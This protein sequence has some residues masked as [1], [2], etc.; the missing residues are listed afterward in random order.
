VGERLSAALF[1]GGLTVAIVATVLSLGMSFPVA[2]MLA[3]L[4][5]VRLVAAMVGLNT[6][7]L[8]AA[9]WGVAKAAPISEDYVGGVALAAIGAA[10]AAGLKA[11]ELSRRAD[12]PLA[13]WLVIVL[14]LANLVAVPLWA[15]A[16]VAGASLGP[17]RILPSLLLLVLLPLLVGVLVRIRWAAPATTLRTWLFR[18]GNVALVVALAA[19]IVT[20]RDL[21]LSVLGSWVLPT[22]LAI[23]ALGLGLGLLV[24]GSD[25]PTRV[26]TSLISGTRFS[27]LGLIIVGTQYPDRSEYLASAITF[28][29]VDFVV[30]LGAAGAIRP[31]A[32]WRRRSSRRVA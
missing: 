16:V 12:L 29:L 9:A 13:V 22:A 15:A 28:A 6:I 18:L 1:T 2:R 30:M 19:G 11:A 32:P 27:A 24:G 4:R 5:R 20:N 10:G 14:Q 7:V 3:P 21:L 31:D 23:V 26:T 8:P 25:A 17:L